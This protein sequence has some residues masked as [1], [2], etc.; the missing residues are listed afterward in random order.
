[1]TGFGSFLLGDLTWKF[2]SMLMAVIHV[3]AGIL[4]EEY[5]PKSVFTVCVYLEGFYHHM[6]LKDLLSVNPQWLQSPMYIVLTGTSH[7][8]SEKL[9]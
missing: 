2:F 6:A 7:L 5:T 3:K 9:K 4:M 8:H 1:M